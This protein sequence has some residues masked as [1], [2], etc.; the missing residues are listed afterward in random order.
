MSLWMAAIHDAGM[1]ADYRLSV[2]LR[3]PS[4]KDCIMYG[5]IEAPTA[6]DAAR[7]LYPGYEIDTADGTFGKVFVSA[8]QLPVRVPW[9]VTEDYRERPIYHH[10]VH[11][12]RSATLYPLPDGWTPHATVRERT[13][14]QMT[15]EAFA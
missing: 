2:K 15:L 12:T 3:A 7:M 4:L 1:I 11:A 6:R 5:P 10:G 14:R 13:V 9:Y 8:E